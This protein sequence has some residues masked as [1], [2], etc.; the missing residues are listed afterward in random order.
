MSCDEHAVECFR[1]AKE[2]TA[3]NLDRDIDNTV[4]YWPCVVMNFI[5]CP[6][7]HHLLSFFRLCMSF[8]AHTVIA[9]FR[10]LSCTRR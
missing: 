3:F 7:N 6:I 5:F 4:L 10:S 9:G 2:W 8:T 1:I